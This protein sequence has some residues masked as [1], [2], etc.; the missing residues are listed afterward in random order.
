MTLVILISYLQDLPKHLKAV[1]WDNLLQR[2]EVYEL[3]EELENCIDDI[4]THV[5][6]RQCSYVIIMASSVHGLIRLHSHFLIVSFLMR[7]FATLQLKFWTKSS[8]Q[9]IFHTTS[10]N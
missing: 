6:C 7:M 9:I 8:S 4:P 3:L 1:N 2:L 5:C 10:F